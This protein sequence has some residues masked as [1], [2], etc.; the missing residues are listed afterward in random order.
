MAHFTKE[1]MW[2]RSLLI[3]L[4]GKLPS[5]SAALARS[6]AFFSKFAESSGF[7]A[8]FATPCML[9]MASIFLGTLDFKM[10]I[11]SLFLVCNLSYLKIS[12]FYNI[13]TNNCYFEPLNCTALLD[14]WLLLSDA[15]APHIFG[16]LQERRG[17]C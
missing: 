7:P 6:S 11:I 15:K 16:I 5:F 14:C 12:V 17:I 3:D 8:T 1:R 9:N 13:N 4:K 10:D 2:R